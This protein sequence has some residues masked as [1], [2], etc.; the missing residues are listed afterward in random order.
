MGGNEGV[1]VRVGMVDDHRSPIWGIERVLEPVADIDLVCAAPTVAEVLAG[2]RLDVV[3]LDLRLDDGTTPREN[4]TTLTEHG[5]ATVVYTSGE[6][7]SLLRSA[8]RAGVLGIVLKS[9][10]EA[11]IID[12]IRAASQGRAVLTTEWAAA[13][14]GD[15]DLYTVDLSPQLQKVLALYA[16][17]ETSARVGEA[18]GVS[19]ET[20]NEYLKRIRQKYAAAGRPTRTKLD[21]FKRA[22]E[23]GW[24][25]VPG[26]GAGNRGGRGGHG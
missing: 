7:P 4:V 2:G 19:A 14:D 3:L 23:D 25:P 6:D 22:V 9:A 11:V 21:L 20:V 18:L 15:P 5:I 1:S 10:D 8:A 16:S 26:R 17:G 13:I 24:L 12:S